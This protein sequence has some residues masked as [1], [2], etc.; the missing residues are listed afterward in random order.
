MLAWLSVWGEVQTCIQPSWCHCHSLSLASV[1]S[2]LVLLFWYRLARIVPD[3]GPLNGRACVCMLLILCWCC[4]H[5][6]RSRVYVSVGCPSACLSHR[7]TAA[8]AAGG[9]AAEHCAGT[10]YRSIVAGA[11]TVYQLQARSAANV[12]S[13]ALKAEGWGSTQTCWKSSFKRATL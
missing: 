9:F 7:S 3:K 1:K 4:P 2:R 6:M 12:G 10:R 11:S 13:V 8:A 5:S